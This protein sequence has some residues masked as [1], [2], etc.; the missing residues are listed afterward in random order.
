MPEE[1]I[2]SVEPTTTETGQEPVG[3]VTGATTT[4][5]TTTETTTASEP[6]VTETSDFTSLP[7]WAQ[8]EIKDA[9]N[10]A[11][12]YRT[13]AKQFDEVFNEWPEDAVTGMLNLAQ[14]IA[15]GDKA[16][17]PVLQNILEGLSDEEAAAIT[18]VITGQ[19]SAEAPKSAMTMEEVQAFIEQREAQ[20]RETSEA[21]RA[22]K[23]ALETLE[24]EIS[25]LGYDVKT[26]NPD[27]DL[28]FFFAQQQEAPVKDFKKA[29]EAVQAYKQELID[30]YVH[31]VVGRNSRFAK[32]AALSGDAPAGVD[33][34]RKNLGLSNGKSQ[35]ALMELL[36]NIE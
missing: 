9:R 2:G 26:R 24:S 30:N 1:A 19:E 16:A 22:Q 31:G 12:K 25:E 18:G 21:E 8:K 6:V 4:E 14:S 28:L 13:R 33:G 23:E 7:E 36:D 27:S 34:G 32:G 17:V 10:D 5:T 15:N 3:A 11:A 29:H 20:Q 35:A